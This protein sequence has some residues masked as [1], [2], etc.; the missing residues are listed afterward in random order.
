VPLSVNQPIADETDR[1][2]VY[3]FLHYARSDKPET[4]S[5]YETEHWLTSH[6]GHVATEH[7]SF[8]DETCL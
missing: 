3:I 8:V 7:A 5:R 6:H 1:F 2:D 4:F